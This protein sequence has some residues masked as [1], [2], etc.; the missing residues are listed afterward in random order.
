VK[1][2]LS[3][4]SPELSEKWTPVRGLDCEH[5]QCFQL[6]QFMEKNIEHVNKQKEG[7]EDPKF[8]PW[9]CEFCG[10]IATEF[11]RDLYIESLIVTILKE[12]KTIKQEKILKYVDQKLMENK[13]GIEF[14]QPI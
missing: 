9:R 10:K 4:D 12:C 11:V 14:V 2:L 5:L 1:Y 6:E 13:E 8:K 3:A 7:K